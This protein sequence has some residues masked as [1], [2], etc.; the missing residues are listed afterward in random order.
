MEDRAQIQ[1]HIKTQGELVRRLKAEKASKEQ[2]SRSQTRLLP[3]RRADQT[4]DW[5]FNQSE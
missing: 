4:S 2:V 3:A 5:S 1:E